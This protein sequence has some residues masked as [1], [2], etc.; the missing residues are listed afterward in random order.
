MGWTETGEDT[1]DFKLL[2]CAIGCIQDLP[3]EMKKVEGK[4]EL[5]FAPMKPES[6]F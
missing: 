1:D 2:T 6:E 5:S 4:P 3:T